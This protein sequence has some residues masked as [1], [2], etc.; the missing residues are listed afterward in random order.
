MRRCASLLIATAALTATAFAQ[1]PPYVKSA[2]PVTDVVR[3]MLARESTNLSG[4]ADL[5]PADKYGYRP[6]PA[7]MTFGELVAHVVQTNVAI[8]SAFAGSATPP[9]APADLQ[10]LDTSGGKEKLTVL[11]KQSFDYC[12]DGLAKTTDAQLA[13]EAAMFG[14]PMGMSLATAVVTIAADWA[15]H[16][17]TAASYLRLNGILPPSARPAAPADR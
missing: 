1:A 9:V 4:A 6:T 8:C 14:R 5:M 12:R 15:D 2:S 10:T 7:Q 16:Y 13:G 3:S 17:S 11:L